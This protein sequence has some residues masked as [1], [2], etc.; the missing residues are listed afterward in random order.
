M[1]GHRGRAYDPS[2]FD[3]VVARPSAQRRAE[4][5]GY[6][7]EHKKTELF[8]IYLFLNPF[9]AYLNFEVIFEKY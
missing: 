3:G 7:I 2:F 4:K 1:S 9:I 8:S 6:R 5:R